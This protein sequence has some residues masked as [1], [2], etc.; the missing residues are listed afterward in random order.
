[1][2]TLRPVVETLEGPAAG[3]GGTVRALLYLALLGVALL[4]LLVPLRAV[5]VP[6]WAS[7]P[8]AVMAREGRYAHSLRPGEARTYVLEVASHGRVK[9]R[10]VGSGGDLSLRIEDAEGARIETAGPGG[11]KERRFGVANPAATARTLFLTVSRAA[12][13]VP[14]RAVPAGVAAA[15]S[16][17]LD[18]ERDTMP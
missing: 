1:M 13:T 12:G 17:E 8:Q 4:L 5:V 11:P 3:A 2:L 9:V 10:F 7:V 14:R 15:S 16:Y 18:L 6:A